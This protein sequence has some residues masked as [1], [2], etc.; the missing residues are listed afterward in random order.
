MAF[1]TR[2]ELAVLSGV[3]VGIVVSSATATLAA[4]VLA[5]LGAAWLVNKIAKRKEDTEAVKPPPPPPPE[6]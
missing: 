6:T 5:G 1:L 3:T 4:P 2:E